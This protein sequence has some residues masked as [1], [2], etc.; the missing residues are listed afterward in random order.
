M[1]LISLLW[2]EPKGFLAIRFALK[3][4]YIMNS[5]DVIGKGRKNIA[6]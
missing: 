6:G 4:S 1:G 2:A 5:Y 3:H